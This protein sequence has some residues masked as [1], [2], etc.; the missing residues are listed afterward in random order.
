MG[1]KESK[2]RPNRGMQDCD[3]K[4]RNIGKLH[5]FFETRMENITIE[6]TGEAI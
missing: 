6:G 1:E 4:G 2:G 3:G 5:K